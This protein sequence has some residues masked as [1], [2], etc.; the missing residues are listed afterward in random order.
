MTIRSDEYEDEPLTQIN[1]SIYERNK[2]KKWEYTGTDNWVYGMMN[3]FDFGF[4]DSEEE[5]KEYCEEEGEEY[6]EEI[7]QY[8]IEL[9]NEFSILE[10]FLK[11]FIRSDWNGSSISDFKEDELWKIVNDKSDIKDLFM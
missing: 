1:N 4:Q 9:L 3:S 10:R 5:I 2:M 11:K 8:R 6:S 7:C